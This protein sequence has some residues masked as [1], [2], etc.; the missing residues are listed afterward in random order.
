VD[1]MQQIKSKFESVKQGEQL[2]VAIDGLSRAGKT[3][4][5]KKLGNLLKNMDRSY[6]ILHI[7]DFIT[8]RSK[9]YNTGNDELYEYY[10]LQWDVPWLEE[11]LFNKLPGSRI[12][13]LPFYDSETDRQVLKEVEIGHASVIIVEGVFLLREQWRNAFDYAVYLDCPRDVRFSRESSP[14]QENLKKFEQRYWKA[15]DFYLETVSP[16]DK[17]DLII[18]C[19]F[20]KE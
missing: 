6:Y 2:V 19:Q 20:L 4:L 18:S 3:T 15:E 8:E 16:M 5:V 7:D 14:T 10:T 13:S 1:G 11:H 12:L 9:R 17:A